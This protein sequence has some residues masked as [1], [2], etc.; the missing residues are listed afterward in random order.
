MIKNNKKGF[1]I[2]ELVIVIAVIAIL[3]AVLIPTFAGVVDK[4]NENAALQEVRT[5]YTV[6]TSEALAAKETP[7][8]NLYVV[9]E[10]NIYIKVS[11]GV[12]TVVETKPTDVDEYTLVKNDDG[13]YTLSKKVN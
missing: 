1:T 6:Y 8:E 9:C 12:A 7:E 2:V 5:A 3:A 13:D 4:A 11:E 10:N